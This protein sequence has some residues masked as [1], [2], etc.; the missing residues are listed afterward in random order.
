MKEHDV[1]LQAIIFHH[2]DLDGRLAG[3]LMCEEMRRKIYYN[4]VE[5][6]EVDYGMEIPFDDIIK[7]G[8]FYTIFIVDFSFNLQQLA[9]LESKGIQSNQIVWIDHHTTAIKNYHNRELSGLRA[10]GLSGAELAYAYIHHIDIS[11]D[12]DYCGAPLIT[13]DLYIKKYQ[14]LFPIEVQTVGNYDCWRFT[15]DNTKVTNARALKLGIDLCWD[16]TKLWDP[17]GY[18]FWTNFT[19]G[20][21]L[22]DTLISSG[23]VIL[24]Y[25]AQMA[26]KT[27]ERNSF[28]TSLI[29]KKYSDIKIIAINSDNHTSLLFQSVYD[30]YEVGIVFSF[31]KV[32]N[33]RVMTFSFYRLGMNPDKK[34]DCGEIASSYGGGG[35]VG[36]AGCV[37]EGDLIFK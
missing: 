5:T 22:Y 2:N 19:Q 29:K 7:E 24:N 14:K 9:V 28:E 3:Y 21:A 15:D 23:K 8:P 27:C 31:K 1:N 30:K 26:K 35:H 32:D 18:Q 36:A 13:E 34:I 37:T 17:E 10:V 4:K 12:E 20:S 11:S 16:K 25:N 33:K 6:Y